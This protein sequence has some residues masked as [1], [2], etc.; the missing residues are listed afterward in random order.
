VGLNYTWISLSYS[1]SGNTAVFTGTNQGIYTVTATNPIG[2]C[3]SQ[4]TIAIGVNTVAPTNSV[5]PTL[6]SINCATNSAVTFSGTVISPTV[7]IQHDWYSPMN[8]LP[9]GVPIATS[10]NTISILSGNVPPGV[11]TLVTTDLV[12]GCTAMKT[13]TIVGLS[14]FPTFSVAS[15]TNFSLGCVPLNQTT[16][17][18]INPVS[19]QTPPA[20]CSYTFLPPTFT[21]AVTSSVILG[22]IN[23]TVTNIPGTWTV[24]VQDN[25]NFCRTQLSIPIIQNTVAPDVSASMYTQ[26]LTCNTPTVLATGSSTTAGTTVGWLMPVTPPSLPN[27]TL[28]IGVPSTGPNTSTSTTSYASFTVVA[29]NT[30][31]SCQSTSVVVISQNFKPPVSSPT[32][33]IGTA[34][35]IYC[36]VNSNPVVLTTGG[37]TVTSGVPFAFASPYLWQGPSPQTTITGASSY[38]A[39]VPGIYTLTIMD[40]Y[41]GCLRT[42]TIQVL[43][44]TQPPVISSPLSQ[45]TLDCGSN[46]ATMNFVLTGTTTGGVR[47]LV[48]SYPLGAA[49]NPTNAPV[50]DLNPLLSGTSSSSVNVSKPG[51]YIYIVSNTLTGCQAFGTVNVTPGN[52]TADFSADPAFGYAPLTVDF[53]NN[54]HTSLGSGS[55]TSIWNFGNG[56]SQSYTTTANAT[57]EFTA[58][59]TYTVMLLAQR[60]SC[61]DTVYKTIKVDIPSKLE[62]PNVFTPNGDGANDVFFLKVANITEVYAIIFDRWGNKVYEVTSSTG[63]IAW[64]GKNLQGK[65]CAVGTYFYVIKGTGKDDKNYQVKGNVSLYR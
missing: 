64:D 42:G 35:A 65:E 30:I 8:P 28:I 58:A 36:T 50:Y 14:A 9:G 45:A 6:Q 39:Y 59:G 61:I 53:T 49:F 41:N 13:V 43:D 2:G 4:Q 37:S 12:N 27:P 5:N 21:G 56:T 3:T 47:Y 16:I 38:S 19:T 60:G 57:S 62:V 40:S 44:R 55:I 46:Q 18:I 26:T 25:S 11:Y 1:V 54:S 10:N 15:P 34:T 24:I 20:T 22:A 7:N 32:I 29:T 31:N 63:N 23:S 33:S 17:S 52:I 48:K 51:Q